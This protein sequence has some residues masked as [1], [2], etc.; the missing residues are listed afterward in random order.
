MIHDNE[1]IIKTDATF[2]SRRNLIVVA[3][4]LNSSEY[5]FF[6]DNTLVDSIYLEFAQLEMKLTNEQLEYLR[7]CEYIYFILILV[8]IVLY[9]SDYTLNQNP[10]RTQIKAIAKEWNIEDLKFCYD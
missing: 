9:E 3:M 10:H 6:C 7:Q 2:E 5:I 1:G 8:N 4:H